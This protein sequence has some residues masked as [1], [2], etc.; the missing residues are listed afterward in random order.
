MSIAFTGGIGPQPFT[1][2]RDP[3]EV[4]EANSR[5][6]NQSLLSL[7][8]ATLLNFRVESRSETSTFLSWTNQHGA[9]VTGIKIERALG[10]GSF[11]VIATLTDLTKTTYE[12]TG[13]A[14]A[15]RYRYRISVTDS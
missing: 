1:N 6:V 4:I 12:D 7:W 10:D 8:L 13:L 5:V 9:G 14:T 11:S 3:I 2:R 15:T